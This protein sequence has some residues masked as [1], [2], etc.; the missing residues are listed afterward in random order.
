MARISFQTQSYFSTKLV[1]YSKKGVQKSGY[2]NI[3]HSSVLDPNYPGKGAFYKQTGLKWWDVKRF[4][5]YLFLDTA[6]D[7]AIIDKIKKIAAPYI[8]VRSGRLINKILSS[9]KIKRTQKYYTHYWSEFSFDW[10]LMRPY[11]ISGR[12]AHNNELGYGEWGT[13]KLTEPEA[14]SRVRVHHVTAGGNALYYLNDPASMNDPS[15]IIER[16]AQIEMTNNYA[17]KFNLVL[18]IIF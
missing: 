5:N 10:S 7:P 14:L 13:V 9:M 4:L 6:D 8:P 2:W 16:T 1:Q 11:P 18:E 17:E 12:T 3:T 15:A